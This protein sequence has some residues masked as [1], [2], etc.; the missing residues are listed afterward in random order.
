M[1]KVIIGSVIVLLSLAAFAREDSKDPVL[2]ERGRL[3]GDYFYENDLPKEKCYPRFLVGFDA[4]KG[5]L[6]Y[7]FWSYNSGWIGGLNVACFLNRVIG[8]GF[9]LRYQ[10]TVNVYLDSTVR[11]CTFIGTTFYGH[12]GHPKSKFYFPT[13]FGLGMMQ[14]N[15][16][17]E[18]SISQPHYEF[19]NTYPALFMSAGVFYRPVNCFSFGFS[20]EFARGYRDRNKPHGVMAGLK[21]GVNCHF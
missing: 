20:S 5:N 21:I 4:G 1:K 10:N 3:T 11:T 18:T 19:K 16:P 14:Y 9:S 8:V 17:Y 13:C 6:L 12:W 2:Y 15:Y 7:S